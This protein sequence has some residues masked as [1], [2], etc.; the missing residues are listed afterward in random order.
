MIYV[1]LGMSK[2]GTSLLSR[3]LHH[4]GINMGDE[5]DIQDS[6]GSEYDKFERSLVLKLNQQILKSTGLHH[7]DIKAPDTLKLSDHQRNRMRKLIQNCQK[8][9]NNWG[10]KEPRT[11]MTY[12]LW[13]SELPEHKIIAIY[14]S[15]HELAMRPRAHIF[16]HI[17]WKLVNRWYENNSSILNHLQDTKMDYLVINYR[18]LMTDNAEF[19]KLCNFVGI[20][21]S[22]QRRKS[23][24]R[25]H[26]I[27]KVTNVRVAECLFTK[28]TNKRM[29]K[30]VQQLD[31]L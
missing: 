26:P 12:P 23:L 5:D 2:S 13:A 30:I 22:D 31:A 16:P 11:C 15:P 7:L 21:L 29:D 28:I 20:E 14:R 17:A 3:I 10:F 25:H 27:T 9:Y 19:E 4:S 8:R 6:I 24:D 18:K 1:V